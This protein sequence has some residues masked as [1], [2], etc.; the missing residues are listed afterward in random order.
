MSL[1]NR[2]YK[3]GKGEIMKK[4]LCLLISSIMLFQTSAILVSAEEATANVEIEN[5]E[6]KEKQNILSEIAEEIAL[7]TKVGV[8]SLSE[9]FDPTVSVT[10]AEFATYTAAMLNADETMAVSYF[11]DVPMNYWA[12]D[13]INALVDRKIIDKSADGTFEPD[14]DITYA[15]ACKIM[16]AAT[17]YK[18]YADP[19]K[20]MNEYIMVANRAGFGITPASR[21]RITSAE[22][23]QLVFNTMRTDLMT[24]IGANDGTYTVKP[25]KGENIFSVYYNIRF[26]DGKIESLYGKSINGNEATK[27]CAY[28][29]GKEC[30]IDE[31]ISL[32]K[33]FGRTVNYAFTYNKAQDIR[34]VIYA[35]AKY[36]N[37]YLNVMYDDISGFEER[38]LTL[39]YWLDNDDS[40]KV[41]TKAAS[42]T[43][44]IVFNG[45]PYGK[46]VKP[47]I[48]ELINGS[49]KGMVEYIS[50]KGES[51]SDLIVITSYEV[52]A[53][54]SYNSSFKKFYSEDGSSGCSLEDYENYAVYDLFGTEL[55]LESVEAGP[56]MIMASDDKEY[57]SV[58]VCSQKV[59]G[60]IKSIKSGNREI[61]VDGTIY[62]V[63]KAFWDK[64]SSKF[65]IGMTYT[66]YLD[67]YDEVIGFEVKQ[68]SGMKL[69][70]ITH[71]ALSDDIFEKKIILKIYSAD[72]DT[73]ETYEFADRFK[74]D[75]ISYDNKGYKDVAGAFP[76]NT[77]L[78]NG[79]LSIER[80]VIRYTTDKDGKLNNIDTRNISAKE[81]KETTLRRT[82]NGQQSLYFTYGT[83]ALGMS[84]YIDRSSLK[85]IVVPSTD[86]NGDIVINGQAV[87]DNINQ[88]A[89]TY[90][91]E[92]W[93]NYNVELFKYSSE[94]L[95]E[96]LA[97]IY[98]VPK[99]EDYNLIMYSEITEGLD[100][101]GE[102]LKMLTGYCLGG[103]TSVP[104]D[105]TVDISSLNLKKGDIVGVE[106]G[107]KNG[108]I[109]KI[110]KMYDAETNKFEDNGSW[111]NPD[112]YWYGGD[113]SEE[114]SGTYRG[115]Y[116]QI[117][118]GYAL[119]TK[120]KL[121]AMSYTLPMAYEGKV[122]EVIPSSSLSVTIYD[123]SKTKNPIYSGSAKD[124]L[125]YKNAGENCDLMLVNA[126]QSTRKQIFV[127]RK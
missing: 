101:E 22:A 70:Y 40:G 30:N 35:E 81:D 124:I 10:R 16:A 125:T 85:Y 47:K 17:G 94:T 8:I 43:A 7:L 108:R 39:K 117:S 37:D 20:I 36:D 4:I 86:E 118:R 29:N 11:T 127:I 12:S 112:R 109:Y 96:D 97:L 71:S 120:G 23:I 50:S 92:D 42:K 78:S 55:K 89:N 111:K 1:L 115:V 5:K 19:D 79:K 114:A 3:K 90:S 44:D 93:K 28:I 27:G 48:D 49:K 102:V 61:N 18:A 26:D 13:S 91:I 83:S 126:Q 25:D 60:T 123:K 52:Y 24:V 119:E 66:I 122:S 107:T 46:E 69:G 74:I 75:E 72:D 100:S 98:T 73:L 116:Y 53:K 31:E 56:Y 110:T 121:T 68:S 34:T 32:D 103:E 6:E 63:D 58:I 15:E 14:R 54:D 76:G 84:H 77:T 105:N 45:R 113:Y 64:Q 87:E 41:K 106:K 38:T 65:N 57:V 99:K 62:V 82:T 95:G 9:E 51:T 80:Q 33:Y 88:Y 67:I 59:D 2:I 21:E 104:I